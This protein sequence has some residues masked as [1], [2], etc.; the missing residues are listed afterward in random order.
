MCLA[1]P[2]RRWAAGFILLARFD[3]FTDAD[4]ANTVTTADIDGDGD[5]DVLSA[6]SPDD[7]LRWYE[8]NGETPPSFTPHSLPVIPISRP[9][10]VAT[11]DLDGDGDLDILATL[12]GGEDSIRWYEN[13]GAVNP[14]FTLRTVAAGVADPAAVAIA[15][16]NKDGE[17]DVVSVSLLGD[18]IR[19]HE[20]NGAS[21]PI[22]ITRTIA[23][24]LIQA[25]SVGL[26]DVNGDGNLDIVAGSF[27]GGFKWLESDGASPP[28]FAEHP[29]DESVNSVKSVAA[30]DV[31]GD[32]DVDVLTSVID[33]NSLRWYENDG[34]TPPTFTAQFLVPDTGG[35]GNVF[36][37]DVDED[38]DLD[39][40]SGITFSN[41]IQWHENDGE[42]D[43]SFTQHI[44]STGTQVR[45][46]SVGDLDGDMDLDLVSAGDLDDTIRWYRQD[47][48]LGGTPF[49]DVH[50]SFASG[51]RAV[52]AADLDGDGDVDA[53]S[54]A[55]FDNSITWHE[56]L[57]MGE[58]QFRDHVISTAEA[59]ASAV[60]IADIDGDSDPDILSASQ[61]GG[62]LRWFENTGGAPAQFISHNVIT[63]GGDAFSVASADMGGDLDLDVVSGQGSTG[64]RWFEN[65]GAAVPTFTPQTIWIADPGIIRTHAADIDGDGDVDVM[66]VVQT[67][68]STGARWHENDGLDPPSF[69]THDLI[70]PG[71]FL[72]V[73]AADIDSDNDIDILIAGGGTQLVR[74]LENIG[75][76]PAQFQEHTVFSSNLDGQVWSVSAADI[77]DDGRI[78]IVAASD[79]GDPVRW[80]RNAGGQPPVFIAHIANATL[81]GARGAFPVDIDADGDIDILS[82]SSDGNELMIHLNETFR[83]DL[84]GDG[85]INST[86]LA[87]LLGSWGVG[88]GSA[89][90]NSDGVTNAAD[91]ALLLGSWG[92]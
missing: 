7:T 33:D 71:S 28:T 21:P 29:I 85:L 47:S 3:I 2:C 66:S 20:N 1:P 69:V 37:A 60:A 53:V 9:S 31:D 84:N 73:G 13:D 6:S 86:D 17:L 18:M 5:I 54:A 52:A 40:V 50:L 22:F 38:G 34:A 76:T 81:D 74:W 87:I 61:L 78:D 88:G 46:V 64:V 67:G 55:S 77:D 23:S 72:N 59:F 4:G 89:D 57:P 14:T 79:A 51:P 44:V 91:L 39:I 24:E 16:M 42:L 11:S 75:G 10:Y 48:A 41:I 80:Y 58:L 8:N 49:S 92:P 35:I 25:N 68:Q 19:W 83:A 65:D 36:A 62:S 56:Q 70:V 63:S 32:G 43:P 26:E 30:A 90:F 82:A 27:S 12:K 15:D 45:H